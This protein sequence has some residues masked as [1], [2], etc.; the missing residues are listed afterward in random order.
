[1]E[2]TI[3]IP[4]DFT[5][6]SLTL[7]KEAMLLTPAEKIRIILLHGWTLPDSISDLLFFSPHAIMAE[8]QSES[9]R[10]A[11]RLLK[12]RYA[13]RLSSLRVDVFTGTTQSAFEHYV[14]ANKIDEAYVPEQ[15][16]WQAVHARSVNP[17][18]FFKA[19]ALPSIGIDWNRSMD[20]T[21]QELG[22]LAT[23]FYQIPN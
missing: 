20:E 19:S 22:L 9:F 2:R 16:T 12:N 7:V 18:P 15:Y 14:E 10:Q 1:M 3:L 11:C 23:L 6:K 5:V 13:S 8:L 4:T 21:L 17:I